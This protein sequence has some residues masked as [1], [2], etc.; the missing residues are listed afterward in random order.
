MEK[1][2][3]LER[4]AQ[5]PLL[6][7]GAMGTMLYARGFSFDRCYEALNIEAPE[8]VLDIHRAYLQAGAELLETNTFGANRYR[9]A[10]HGLDDR[11]TSLNHAGVAL[12]RRAA[13]EANR[14][15]WIAG[16][17]GPLG[18][19]LAPLGRAKAVEARE[20]FRE[21]IAAL[22]EAGVDALIL[23]TF[24]SLPELLEAI[25]AAQ[26]TAPH[27]PVIAEMTF[28]Q[29]GYTL[30]GHS[31]EEV[32]ETL[33]D[34]GVPIIGAN[35]SVGPAKL[36]PVI[37]RM[38]SR[39]TEA[40][41]PPPYLVVM[42]NAGWP[43]MAAGRLRYP[44]TPDYFAEYASRFR[45]LGVRIL[46][47]CCGTTPEHI[48]A[49]RRALETEAETPSED[50]RPIFQGVSLPAPVEPEPTDLARRLQAGLFVVSVEVDP[51][52]GHDASAML[53]VA[54]SLKAGGVDALN[55]ADSP[56]ARL[57]MSPWALA[58]LVQ[59]H[60]GLETI[61]HFPTRGRNL[62]RIQSDLLAIH[63]L[64]VRNL[65][66]VMGDPP[67]QGDYPEA[68][69]AMDIVPSGLVRLI[70]ERF[71]AG[72]DHAGESI[73]RPTAF[74]V[75][76]ALNF[77][78]PDPAREIKALRRKIRAGA[79]FIMTQPVYEPAALK[80]FLRRYEEEE[81][82]IPIP[83]LAGVLP[84]L[85]LRHAEFLHNEV[86]GIRVP[87]AIRERLRR[88]GE[89]RA[90]SEG[91]RMAQEAVV[92]LAEFTQGLYVM[93]PMGRYDLVFQLMEAIPAHRRGRT[94]R[95]NGGSR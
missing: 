75:G 86:P 51:P 8:V 42:P 73:G 18:V 93:P 52:R 79:D 63:A 56:M 57:R 19:P 4:L 14:P 85:S 76:V 62:L 94:P 64:G 72:L 91:L 88:A 87:E 54:R 92:E 3:L 60:V 2:N 36:L 77:N 41:G 65:F 83:I 29:D 43:E 90:R 32:V 59:N 61:L 39:I 21:Q 58:F 35:C 49:M 30:M 7:D 13:Q 68:T 37:R 16:S 1:P 44:A 33:L 66:V 45:A 15:V 69:D 24:S 55:I 12:A 26:E 50:R 31:P 20:A 71:N 47:G 28:A 74:F 95:P 53:E 17:V 25:R 40:G 23:E 9:L 67:A 34:L 10:E 84:L 11:V 78:A 89:A 5:G 6:A 82:P 27:V 70:K 46:G 48:A 80:N 81:G 22:V 38:A